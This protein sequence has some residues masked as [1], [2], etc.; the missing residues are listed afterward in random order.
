MCTLF[1]FFNSSVADI[2]VLV[3]GAGLARLMHSIA[4]LGN[5]HVMTTVNIN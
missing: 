1:L 2:S 5:L 3:P 4:K